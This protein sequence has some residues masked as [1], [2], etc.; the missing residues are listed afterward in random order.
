ML[1]GR[2]DHRVKPGGD[3]WWMSDA[4][5]TQ[6]PVSG[7]GCRGSLK[8]AGEVKISFLELLEC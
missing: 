2:M 5:N 8:E 3:D 7:K 1:Q 4:L 6:V